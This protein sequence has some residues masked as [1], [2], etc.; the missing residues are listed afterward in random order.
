[1]TPPQE[2]NHPKLQLINRVTWHRL[3]IFCQLSCHYAHKVREL[4]APGVVIVKVTPKMAQFADNASECFTVC[5]A[6]FFFGEGWPADVMNSARATLPRPYYF[7]PFRTATAGVNSG[8]ANPL[9]PYCR[10]VLKWF[11][12]VF[13]ME[14]WLNFDENYFE[15]LEAL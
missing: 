11:W 9:E 2:Q 13:E 1:M 6:L 15:K 5:V 7:A 12:W 10:A 3:S 14:R 4:L 8:Y